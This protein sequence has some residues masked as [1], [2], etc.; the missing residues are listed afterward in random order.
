MH[1][2]C[3]TMCLY[4]GFLPQWGS[5]SFHWGLKRYYDLNELRTTA[6][7]YIFNSS[8]SLQAVIP[9]LRKILKNF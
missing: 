8:N 5:Q 9:S 1:C 6:L 3:K 2:K 7:D 4:I